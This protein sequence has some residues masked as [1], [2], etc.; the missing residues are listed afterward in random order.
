MTVTELNHKGNFDSWDKIELAE[1]KNGKFRKAIGEL[2]YENDEIRAWSILLRPSEP[3]R[4]HTSNYSCTSLTDGLLVSG[5][6]EGSATLLLFNKG[7]RFFWD[8]TENEMIH[9]LENVGE[10]TVE[11]SIIEEKPKWHWKPISVIL[12]LRF[13][14]ILL[15]QIIN[16]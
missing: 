13:L 11:I 14:S 10:A 15:C 6:I 16:K 9:A 4:R 1:I 7:D 12:E 5:N 8:C 2:F 3:F